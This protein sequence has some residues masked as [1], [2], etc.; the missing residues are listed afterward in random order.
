MADHPILLIE[1]T[2]SL[3]LVYR[4]VLQ[5]AGH[6]VEVAG[7]AYEG[8]K[9][10][11]ELAPCVVLLDLILPDRDGL[12]LMK[13]C[14]DHE[15]RSRFIVITANGTV[16]RAVQAMRAGA[17]D[18]LL[19]PFQDQHIKQVV[20]NAQVETSIAADIADTQTERFIHGYMGTSDQMQNVLSK[21]RTVAHSMASVFIVGEKG[22]GKEITCRMIHRF[23]GRTSGPCVVLSCSAIPAETLEVALFGTQGKTPSGALH[24]AHEGTLILED[25]DAIPPSAQ[26][27]LLRFLQCA[28]SDQNCETEFPNQPDVRIISTMTSDPLISVKNGTLREDLFYRLHVIPIALPVLRERGRDLLDIGKYMLR[29]FSKEEGRSFTD[30]SDEVSAILLRHPW[31]GNIRQLQNI[32]RNIVVLN[33]GTVVTQSMLPP[34]LYDGLSKVQSSYIS[35]HET[36]EAEPLSI[37]QLVGCSLEEIEQIAIEET[38]TA[39]DGSIPRAA[40]ILGVA[41][42]TLYRKRSGWKTLS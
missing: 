25:V 24:Q 1:D 12:D 8:M 13:E 17:F 30:F 36:A 19:K 5:S 7:T 28:N 31:P 14:L 21:L 3:Q 41:P 35:G 32:I 27:K 10:Y 38:I 22:V 9:K 4:S 15:N 34:E 23:S 39:C 2:P 29:L 33:T 42:S 6:R 40:K 20:A 37:K 11:K 26:A 18:F 16:D